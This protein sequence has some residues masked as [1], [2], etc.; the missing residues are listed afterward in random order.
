M[1][2]YAVIL[3]PTLLGAGCA[4]FRPGGSKGQTAF[5]LLVQAVITGLAAA[6][7]CQGEAIVTAPIYFTDTLTF[8]LAL[9]PLASF[10]CLL[11]TVC[12]LLTILYA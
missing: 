2:L 5:M 12:W 4:F 3:L 8:S 9:D 10:F 7:A 11:T 1:I 6:M